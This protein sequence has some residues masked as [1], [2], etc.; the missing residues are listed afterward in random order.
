[1]G[2]FLKIILWLVVALVA[3]VAVAAV[4][5]PMVVD[6]NDYKAEI[7][8]AVEKQTGRTL[9][10]DGDIALSVFPWL[11]L[12]IGP[13]QFSNAAGFD[14]PSMA[15]MEAVQV[16][17]KLLP[18]LRKQL[19]VDKVRLS[20]LQLYLAK[21]KR[22]QTNWADLTATAEAAETGE[23]KDKA[24]KE[25]VD[26]GKASGL[27]RL[28]IGGIEL[29]DASIHW[30]DLSSD[31]R[32]V[33]NELSLTTGAI[34]PGEAFD[35]D[36]QLQLASTQPAMNTGLSLSGELLIATD[37]SAITITGA[38]L[39]VDAQGDS[40]PA[41][42]VKAALTTD[43]SLGLAAQTLLLPNIVLDT[44][45]LHITASVTG[46]D[47]SSDAPRFNG[48]LDIAEFVP[49]KVLQAL[50]EAAPV[51]ADDSVLGK[52]DAT[53]AWDASLQH[54]AATA[55]TAHLDET[56]I[57]GEL[58]VQSFDAPAITFALMLDQI[59]IDRYLPP[60]ADQEGGTGSGKAVAPSAGN[61][62][63]KGAGK[64]A[65]Q[66][67]ELPLEPLRKL[68]LNG[69]IRM[70]QLKAFKL[71]SRDV[72][73]QIRAQDG[74]LKISPLTAQLYDGAINVDLRLDARKDTPRFSVK[75]SLTGVQA[76]PLLK[77]LT[78]DDKLLGT[79]EVKASLEGAGS[80]ADAILN[81]L[82]GDVSFSFT[83]GAVKGVNIA[84]LIR[85]AQATLK[86]QP[87][88]KQEQPNQTDFALM[89]GSAK[90]TNG[91]V[92]N[93]D[94]FMQSPLLR[95]AGAGEV[96]LPQ[97]TVDYTLTT[98]FVGSLEGQGGKGD[99]ELKGVSVP[100]HVGGTFSKLTYAPDLGA[101]AKDAAKAEVDKRVSK[102]KK[103]LEEKLGTEIPD[104]LLKGLF[105]K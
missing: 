95:I 92:K 44:L 104:S 70:A 33:V 52:A 75:E 6:P 51:T 32:Y 18:L 26:D 74:I 36:L 21:D 67:G 35:L 15:R 53:L 78:G 23:P 13:T 69:D 60:A 82:T 101:V 87:A 31:S 102:E 57:N 4:V 58:K 39:L 40:L 30:D 88:P 97:E 1:M 14:E 85:K 22:G 29:T 55:L 9:T 45:G 76:G 10:I 91:L 50:G 47:I 3:L 38:R 48:S 41:G 56:T 46:A 25:T 89:R 43:I 86:G 84:A 61:K 12:D 73:I 96:S 62:G 7:A 49:R 42:Q 2:K 37:F 77:D 105:D 17:V 99:E 20:G 64:S 98:K 68:N 34:E 19:E 90:V 81:T 63:G 66:S 54:F 94:L 24:S 71:R 100:V 79:A 80:N 72:L 8:T 28:V 5:L 11:G 83:D 93:D 16:R 65:P 27:D 103:K 59:D